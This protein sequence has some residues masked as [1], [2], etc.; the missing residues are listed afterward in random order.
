MVLLAPVVHQCGGK[1]NQLRMFL[2]SILLLI[3][4]I[5]TAQC[6]YQC[7]PPTDLVVHYQ[8][9][10][11]ILAPPLWIVWGTNLPPQPYLNFSCPPIT[12][13][14]YIPPKNLLEWGQPVLST[15]V[16][17]YTQ[18]VPGLLKPIKFNS[19]ILP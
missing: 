8:P 9:D 14:Q 13:L 15:T 3:T 10:Y 2:I 16:G 12:S 7:L 5:S 4:R 6:H 18:P 1:M 11:T 19:T 17:M